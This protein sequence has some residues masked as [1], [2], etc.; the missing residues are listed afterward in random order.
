MEGGREDSR[1]TKQLE[2]KS[3]AASQGEKHPP[4]VPLLLSLSFSPSHFYVPFFSFQ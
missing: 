1:L 4:K 2:S 3:S